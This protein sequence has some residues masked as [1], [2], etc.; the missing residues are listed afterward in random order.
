MKIVLLDAATLGSD[1]SLSAIEK[2]GSLISYPQ[3]KP[4]ETAGRIEDADI[5]ITNK[6]VINDELMNQSRAL[7]L[8]CVAATGMN[9]IDLEAAQKRHISVKNV[10]GYSTESVVQSTFS[11][12]FYLL[13]QQAYY[14]NYGKN[15]WHH[16]RI[17]THL[18]RP[19]FEITGKRWGIIGLGAI[20]R[21]VAEI[22]A[23]F[24]CEVVYFSTSGK[25]RTADFKQ[26]GLDELFKTCHI[27]SIHAPLNPQT[28][29]LIGEKQ[30]QLLQPQAV[31]VNV[32]RGGIID[33][34]ALAKALD[35]R[36]IYAGLDVISTEPISPTNPLLKVT[37]K[38][39]LC[40]TP[41]MAWTSVEARQRLIEGIAKN[42]EVWLAKDER[43][44]R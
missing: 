24:G 10:A 21:R 20:G 28:L 12:V 14:D 33:E 2:F 43:F 41:H 27:V 35:E 8:I 11:H 29:N 37:H 39:R 44:F 19:F 16:S 34:P 30:L 40:I 17:F 38:E 4:N 42:I 15:R 13:N 3:T 26:V 25:N 1:I 23:A 18:S 31:V 22:A 7:K 36:P 5:V 32:G 6:V 9:N